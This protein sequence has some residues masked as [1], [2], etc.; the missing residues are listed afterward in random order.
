MQGGRELTENYP[1][2]QVRRWLYWVLWPGSLLLLLSLVFGPMGPVVTLVALG[3]PILAWPYLAA[4]APWI[5]RSRLAIFLVSCVIAAIVA[6]AG[7]LL[8]VL[9]TSAFGGYPGGHAS[10]GATEG[11]TFIF[12]LLLLFSSLV[13]AITV[14]RSSSSQIPPGCFA[15]VPRLVKAPTWIRVGGW[16]LVL[17]GALV[18]GTLLYILSIPFWPNTIR[19]EVAAKSSCEK[20]VELYEG[21][22]VAFSFDECVE[23]TRAD[24]EKRLEAK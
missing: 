13:C 19:C 14:P 16:L 12:Y 15:V 11:F 23:V 18:S 9:A 21:E 7:S 3:L 6:P 2:E 1:W 17:A 20:S 22:R 8:L 10:M 4:A 5:E 24:C